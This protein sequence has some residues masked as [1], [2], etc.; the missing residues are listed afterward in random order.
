MLR[1]IRQIFLDPVHHGHARAAATEPQQFFDCGGVA[2][3]QRLDRAVDPVAHPAGNA[4][5]PRLLHHPDT[6]ADPLHPAADD[7]AFAVHLRPIGRVSW[8]KRSASA[9]SA[10]IAARRAAD[11]AS[12]PQI[13]AWYNSSSAPSACAVAASSSPSAIARPRTR[14]PSAGTAMPR[15][16]SAATSTAATVSRSAA[17][18]PRC[19]LTWAMPLLIRSGAL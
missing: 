1:R 12:S 11:S 2:G 9:T 19:C 4:Q 6:E 16:A 17:R 14:L 7:E 10:A 13:S 8:R 5:G 15:A 3:D 18:L